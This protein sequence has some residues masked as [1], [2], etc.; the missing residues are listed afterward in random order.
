MLTLYYEIAATYSYLLPEDKVEPFDDYY[1]QIF[2]KYPD[3]ETKAAF[4]TARLLAKAQLTIE[5][6]DIETQ[7]SILPQFENNESLRP[8]AIW[9]KNSIFAE[10]FC[11]S[12]QVPLDTDR[13]SRSLARAFQDTK[14]TEYNNIESKAKRIQQIETDIEVVSIIAGTGNDSVCAASLCLPWLRDLLQTTDELPGSGSSEDTILLN[15]G[16]R[17]KNMATKVEQ[18]RDLYNF[19]I[20][21]NKIASDVDYTNFKRIFTGS[22]A[23]PKIKWSGD[24]SEL[25]AMFKQMNDDGVLVGPNKIW[26]SVSLSFVRKDGNSFTAKQINGQ[27]PSAKHYEF[28]TKAS[29]L[30]KAE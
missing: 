11:F 13:G 23:T 15:D 14:K 9:L 28:A 4:D 18:I 12:S 5:A 1:Y 19:L 29:N 26:E 16:L 27:H 21:E 24:F 6:G 20:K 10:S 30:L 8:V 22:Y 25:M 3:V 7:K 17:Y 2:G